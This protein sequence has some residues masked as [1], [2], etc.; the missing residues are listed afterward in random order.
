[1]SFDEIPFVVASSA[2]TFV[3]I[4]VSVPGCSDLFADVDISSAAN[5]APAAPKANTAPNV[6]TRNLF[7]HPP[8]DDLRTFSCTTASLQAGIFQYACHACPDVIF[9]SSARVA[10]PDLQFA[11]SLDASFATCTNY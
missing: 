7:I 2:F 4:H 5:V 9:A 8:F 1:M 6:V 11:W 3:V 10:H